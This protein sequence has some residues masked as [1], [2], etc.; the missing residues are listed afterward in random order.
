MKNCNLASAEVELKRLL[1]RIGPSEAVDRFL[2]KYGPVRTKRNYAA[3][4]GYYFQWL[5]AQGIALSPDEL[6][7]DNIV[8]VLK[9]EPTDVKARRWHTD[10]L[11]KYVNEW[12]AEEAQGYSQGS[13]VL[14][15]TVV[16][17]FYE[18]ND[19]ELWAT[20]RSPS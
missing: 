2:A 1:G 15:A 10:L 19:S 13:R 6:I 9:S 8:K 16:R 3:Q 17:R 7:Q 18:R 12:M 4:L 5:K 20:S 11:L 14:A